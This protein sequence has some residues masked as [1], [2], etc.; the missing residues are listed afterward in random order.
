MSKGRLFLLLLIAVA[1]GYYYYQ[2]RPGPVLPNAV[3]RP[4]LA[5]LP[6]E[7]LNN[8]ADLEYLSKA[9]TR[10]TIAKLGQL[11]ATRLD[12]IA[13]RSIDGYRGSRKSLHAIGRELD[14][15]YVIEGGVRRDADALFV[16][17]RLTRVSDEV[18]LWAEEVERPLGNTSSIQSELIDMITKS[19][20]V[21][22]R[23]EDRA[24]MDRATTSVTRARDAYLRGQDQ[25]E[26]G[27]APS[28]RQCIASFEESMKA[29]PRY[30]R[31]RAALAD[32]ELQSRHNVDRAEQLVRSAL[33]SSDAIPQ[34]HVVL[35]DV[36]Y[37]F[38]KDD[39]GAEAEFKKALAL[40]PSDSNACLRYA[41]F[42]LTKNRPDEALAQAQRS[43]DLDPFSIEPNLV[44]GR[45]MTASKSYDAAISQLEKTVALDRNSPEIRYWL[46]EAYL[47]R[48]MYEDAIREFEKATSFGPDVPEYVASLGEAYAAAKRPKEAS[49]QLQRLRDLAGKRAVAPELIEDLS[50][51][52]RN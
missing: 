3:R 37:R 32:V 9:F 52:I 19:L 39:K 20:N 41:E 22:I 50:K 15:D 5:V 23:P 46:A 12:V 25:C 18:R 14:V 48:G 42:L 38:R 45:I 28:I 40:N 10:E 4:V 11:G 8:R 21:T 47:A 49:A 29:D 51:R 17:A 2:S 31:A 1:A 16:S 30:A 6:F 33:A 44:L 34:A 36:L 13:Y 24:A 43:L 35:G 7:N 27:D 26:R